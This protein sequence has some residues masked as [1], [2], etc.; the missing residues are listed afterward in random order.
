MSAS[1]ATKTGPNYRSIFMYAQEGI[2]Q[3]SLD[4]TVLLVNPAFARIL[5]YDDPESCKAGINSVGAQVYARPETR[6]TVVALLK[7]RGFI[8]NYECEVRRKDGSI[9][10]V[11]ENAHLVRDTDGRPLFFEGTFIDITKIK[12]AQE[13]LRHSEERYR[14]LVEHSQDGVF[15]AT[16]GVIKFVNQA[17][18][19]MLGYAA[20]E[21]QGVAYQRVIAPEDSELMDDLWAKRRAGQW[22]KW[23]YEVN[24]LK[25]DG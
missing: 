24:L 18:A 3:T 6:A 22:E 17:F 15:V 23:A 14:A 13:T 10:W 11:S 12:E 21:M 7:Q 16:D 4:G 5:G 1:D 20:A 8:E 2:Y 25:K 19:D 9:L